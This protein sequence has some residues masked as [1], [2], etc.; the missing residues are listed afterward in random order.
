LA[1]T[2]ADE[3]ARHAVSPE[4]VLVDP[5]LAQWTRLQP[6]TR[7]LDEPRT[8]AVVDVQ[9]VE[10]GSVWSGKGREAAEVGRPSGGVIASA[11][12]VVRPSPRGVL[13]SRLVYALAFAGLGLL[14]L[15]IPSLHRHNPYSISTVAHRTAVNAEGT[16][17]APTRE[18]S[19]ASSTIARPPGQRRR[20]EP[21]GQRGLARIAQRQPAR[22][23]VWIPVPK[24]SGYT[25]QFFKAGKK[26][27]GAHPS[28]A[29][30]AVPPQW[31][32]GGRRFSLSRGRYRW[33][34]RPGFGTR[35]ARHYG[36]AIVRSLL[37]VP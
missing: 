7:R 35:G 26:I 29:R 3:L 34:V 13:R 22:V 30:L 5:E 21:R 17:S 24:A 20:G 1:T 33:I 19:P 15:T 16:N 25:V 9:E 8:T 4:L 31:L 27:L 2:F 32:Y 6:P 18:F 37:V 36:P 10:E 23:F 11:E 28:R 12:Q 14:A